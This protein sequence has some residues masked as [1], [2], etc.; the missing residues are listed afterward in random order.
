MY[1]AVMSSW[2]S[3]QWT[4]KRSLRGGWEEV[5]GRHTGAGV[6]VYQLWDTGQLL[7]FSNPHLPSLENGGH[8]FHH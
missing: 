2:D 4:G 3:K 8:C 1:Q 7:T 6:Q 5:A